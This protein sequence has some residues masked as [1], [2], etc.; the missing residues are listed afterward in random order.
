MGDFTTSNCL[1][2]LVLSL[3]LSNSSFEFLTLKIAIDLAACREQFD[4]QRT[5]ELQNDSKMLL[6][7]KQFTNSKSVQN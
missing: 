6:N 1:E 5:M 7:V 2:A 4:I 3:T